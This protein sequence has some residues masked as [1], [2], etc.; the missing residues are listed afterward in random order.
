M[1]GKSTAYQANAA[2][3]KVIL[4]RSTAAEQGE[5]WSAMSVGKQILGMLEATLLNSPAFFERPPDMF[6]TAE[7]TA[8]K[9]AI[10][11]W[12]DNRLV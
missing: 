4:V 10:L 8:M 11:P 6:I 7:R 1:V 9:H 3:F 2:F 5:V 12:G